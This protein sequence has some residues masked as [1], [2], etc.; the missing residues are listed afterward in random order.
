MFRF[1]TT[2]RN[3]AAHVIH[4]FS[5]SFMILGIDDTAFSLFVRYTNIQ[6]IIIP[7]IQ[8]TLW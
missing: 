1:Y 8:K 5:D 4:N 7:T 6:K 3:F 2:L